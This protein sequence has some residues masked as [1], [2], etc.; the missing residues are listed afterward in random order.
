MVYTP[1]SAKVTR[2]DVENLAKNLGLSGVVWENEEFFGITS[3]E[4]LFIMDKESGHIYYSDVN[5]TRPNGRDLPGNLPSDDE[6]I[7]LASAFLKNAQIMP[8]DYSAT[9]TLHQNKMDIT[10]SEH[11]FVA[12]EDVQVYFQRQ[13]EGH[14]VMGSRFSVDIGANG[15]IIGL[16]TNWRNYVPYKKYPLK[17]PEQAYDE[18]KKTALHTHGEPD[19]VSVNRITLVYYTQP[20]ADKEKYLQPAYLFEG[21]F[22]KDGETSSFGHVYIPATD[23]ILDTL[24]Q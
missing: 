12:W 6:A 10:N 16:N 9:R 4:F 15:D 1:V 21:N 19:S 11:H 22:Q 8:K 2:S 13:I 7:K 18:F 20:A 23:D 3:K 5:R 17:S 14:E 24:P